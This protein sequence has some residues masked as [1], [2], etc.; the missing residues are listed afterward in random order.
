MSL[1][2]PARRHRAQ[3]RQRA[4]LRL[5]AG[6]EECQC[7]LDRRR[8]R[9]ESDLSLRK[10]RSFINASSKP[11][12]RRCSTP[13]VK[14]PKTHS[15]NRLWPYAPMTINTACSLAAARSVSAAPRASGCRWRVDALSPCQRRAFA[16][17]APS[18]SDRP[19]FSATIMIRINF[20]SGQQRHRCTYRPGCLRRR[21]PGDDHRFGKRSGPSPRP[22]AGRK[23]TS[24]EVGM[25]SA[26]APEVP[27]RSADG[28]AN[29]DSLTGD[30]GFESISLHRRVQCEP[31]FVALA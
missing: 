28:I 23:Y 9:C 29:R 25:R 8:H 27:K 22:P 19:S 31:D 16:R 13:W 26:T 3:G 24:K 30:R 12:P 14:P 21:L 11:A 1:S 6:D 5:L 4:R 20:R 10:P 15:R 7:D 17:R 18:S 2:Q